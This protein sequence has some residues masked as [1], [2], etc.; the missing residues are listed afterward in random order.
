[1][2]DVKPLGSEGYPNF[3]DDSTEVFYEGDN[4]VKG[5]VK[6]EQTAG[7]YVFLWYQDP[8]WIA[9]DNGGFSMSESLLEQ[10]PDNVETIWV[11][12][13]RMGKLYKFSV[14]QYR[15]DAVRETVRQDDDRLNR[16]DAELQ[17]AV[18]R[19]DAKEVYDLP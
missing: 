12:S 8:F 3:S 7:E 11:K 2:P 19:F 10:I 16:D 5:A 9:T 14:E 4:S 1:M 18:D 6:W 17:Y 15:D 13:T